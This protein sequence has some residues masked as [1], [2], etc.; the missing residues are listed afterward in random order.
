MKKKLLI[1]FLMV[2]VLSFTACI[3]DKDVDEPKETVT[4]TV[5]GAH[6]IH[7]KINETEIDYLQEVSVNG[8]DSSIEIPLVDTSAVNLAESGKYEI[9]YYYD[10]ATQVK[11]FL[12][13]YDLPEFT[14]KEGSESLS[15][16][17]NEV[18]TGILNGISAKDSFDNEL[19]VAIVEYDGLINGD[20][21]NNYGTF[22]IQY[23]AEDSVGNFKIETRSVEVVKNEALIPVITF[24]G[25][26]DV[27]DTQML[28]DID[29]K[30]SDLK[31][32]SINGSVISYTINEGSY[33]I[34]TDTLFG[35]LD[36]GAHTIKVVTDAGYSE[37]EFQLKDEQAPIYN[38]SGIN[39]WYFKVNE[40]STLP[41]IEKASLKQRYE[42]NYSLQDESGNEVVI[43]SNQFTPTTV[44]TYTYKAEFVRNDVTSHTETFEYQ[45]LSS[46]DYGK[47]IDSANSLQYFEQNLKIGSGQSTLSYYDELIGGRSGAYKLTVGSDAPANDTGWWYHRIHMNPANVEFKTNISTYPIVSVE[48]YLEE[49]ANIAFVIKGK[50]IRFNNSE[51]KMF[52]EGN[53]VT[54]VPYG[55]WF[56]AEITVSAITDSTSSPTSPFNIVYCV[57]STSYYINNLIFK[58]ETEFLTVADFTGMNNWIYKAETEGALPRATETSKNVYTFTEVPSGVTALTTLTDVQNY[59]FTVA[60]TYR[61]TYEATIDG[62][63]FSKELTLNVLSQT[64]YDMV[65]DPANSLQLYNNNLKIGSGG[66]MKFEYYDGTIGERDG[67]YKVTSGPTANGW[68]HRI[69]F[70]PTNIVFKTNISTYPIVS[71]DLY[72]E[73]GT[74]ITFA[75]KG[76]TLG[77]LDGKVKMYV[78]GANVTAIPYGKW[79]TVEVVTSSLTDS[80]SGTTSA[81][82]IISSK[83]NQAYYINNLLFKNQSEFLQNVEFLG[84]DNWVYGV[85]VEETLPNEENSTKNEYIFTKV[86]EGVTGL[87]TITNVE[88]Y[89][90]TVAGVYEYTYKTTINGQNYSNNLTLTVLEDTDYAKLADPANSMQFYNNNLKI[91]SGSGMKFEY[92]DGTIGERDGS[93]KVTS[94]STANGWYHRIHFDPTNTVFKTKISSYPIISFDLYLEQGTEITFAIK[95]ANMGILDGRIKMY[96]DGANVT[97]IP[98]G[99]W[100]TVEVTVSS[101]T[102]STTGNTSAFNIISAKPSQVYYINNL[103]FKN[104]NESLKNINLLGLDNWIYEIN[105]E[106]VLPNSISAT[107]TK[108]TFTSM[109][110]GALNPENL[111]EANYTFTTAGLYEYTYEVVF[112]GKKYTRNL[113]LT[114]HSS[115]DYA[116]LADPANSMQFYNQNLK[117]GSGGMKFDYYDGTVGDR[118][119]AYKVTIASAATTSNKWYNRIHFDPTN[120]DFKANIS[121][122]SIISFDLYLEEGAVI[123]FVIK[124]TTMTFSDGRLKMYVDGA[125]VTAIPYGQWFT[126]EV[127]VSSIT[128]SSSGPTSAFNITCSSANKVFYINDLAFKNESEFI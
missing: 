33:V 36:L 71:F 105:V 25:G 123:D 12:Y 14:I 7:V 101:I 89:T 128:D 110:E 77:L 4:Y 116:K 5:T 68:Y 47:I 43:N 52:V 81:F 75:I 62:N 91:G 20:G 26:F 114:V 73:Q 96:I 113:S 49:N 24:D 125:N 50:V 10:N 109:P 103:L 117:I 31:L 87:T 32:I 22:N 1:L 78:D 21:S 119:G 82:N 60:G 107:E 8:S 30:D 23:M 42:I 63:M 56:T 34:D 19:E 99:Q 9:I 97:A 120:V 18:S 126:V 15:L 17:Y 29:I 83:P 58:T 106:G 46:E 53:K 95:G 118:E 111:T 79:F 76:S 122:Y 41:V 80:T 28:L 48:L 93:Y 121:D 85:N 66:G 115:E 84:M 44:G 124:G 74:E 90:F 6:D 72:L 69:H 112:S 11:S 70:D 35:Q 67:S 51:V 61:Y 2:F 92:F 59:T 39:N 100:F 54:E 27:L 104:D 65:A 98:Y 57:P 40:L 55:Q 86:P 102:D 88:N 94:G 37:I 16:Q 3:T 64:D 45:V 127:I 38:D 108:Y 13:V